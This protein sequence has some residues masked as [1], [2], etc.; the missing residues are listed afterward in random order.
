MRGLGSLVL[1]LKTVN[2]PVVTEAEAVRAVSIGR[3][4]LSFHSLRASHPTR[5]HEQFDN[6]FSPP[7]QWQD[8]ILGVGHQASKTTVS[9]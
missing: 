4:T 7:I 9:P 6:V 8:Y 2:L 1:Q 3:Y 5:Q